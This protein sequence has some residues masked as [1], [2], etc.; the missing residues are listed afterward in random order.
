MRPI[1]RS[2]SLAFPAIAFLLLAAGC[3]D[4]GIS[5]PEPGQAPGAPTIV[6]LT[7]MDGALRLGF[8]PPASTGDSPITLYT[9]TCSGEQDFRSND[10]T[11]TPLTVDHLLNGRTYSCVV[12][13]TN[14][15]GTG[16]ASAAW[17]G[18][19]RAN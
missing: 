14:A 16:P 8:T 13:A 5:D 11:K 19:P 1:S 6:N 7:E 17:T 4:G 15:A 18:T 10:G 2:R 9:G 12:T 3:G